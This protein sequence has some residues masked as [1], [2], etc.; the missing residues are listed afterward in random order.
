MTLKLGAN[1]CIARTNNA[2]TTIAFS[3]PRAT[4]TRNNMIK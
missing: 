3:I 2:K 4:T 1:W